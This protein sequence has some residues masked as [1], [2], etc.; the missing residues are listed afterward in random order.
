MSMRK[1]YYSKSWETMGEKHGEKE[2][3]QTGIS[4]TIRYTCSITFYLYHHLPIIIHR[5]V[6]KI[7]IIL[8]F[9]E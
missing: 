4:F 1:I 3:G 6:I 8:G 7:E 2:L 9:K 5:I